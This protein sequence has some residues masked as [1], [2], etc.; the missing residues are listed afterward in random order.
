MLERQFPRSTEKEFNAAVAL[1]EMEVRPISLPSTCLSTDGL[2]TDHCLLTTLLRLQDVISIDPHPH[3]PA[4]ML[5]KID[6]SSADDPELA[7]VPLPFP[8]LSACSSHTRF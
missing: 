8:G 3:Y 6:N 2:K 1:L 4:E 7:S 5:I